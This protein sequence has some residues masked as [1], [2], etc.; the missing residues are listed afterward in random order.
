MTLPSY[1]SLL[2]SITLVVQ[3]LSSYE[4]VPELVSHLHLPVQSGSN[5]TL[6]AMGRGHT[7]EQY[8]EKIQ[9]LKQV[10][11]DLSISSDFIVAFPGESEED[12]EQ[13]LSLVK[14][15]DLDHQFFLHYQ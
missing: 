6:K 1:L 2:R 10:R 9:R 7:R 5:A 8:I 15:L 11:P 4:H 13:T 12:F 14:E 3:A